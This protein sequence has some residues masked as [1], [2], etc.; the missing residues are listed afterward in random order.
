[1]RIIFKSY[2]KT[3]IN[4]WIQTLGTILFILMMCAIVI[5]MLTSPLQISDKLSRSEQNNNKFDTYIN[6][7]SPTNTKNKLYNAGFIYDYVYQNQDYKVTDPDLKTTKQILAIPANQK[8]QIT[9][10]SDAYKKAVALHLATL[11]ATSQV[12]EQEKQAAV[13]NEIVVGMESFQLGALVDT[14]TSLPLT[15][16]EKNPITA[17]INLI[18]NN[19]L[20]M[21]TADLKVTQDQGSKNSKVRAA[22][23][24]FEYFKTLQAPITTTD[25]ANII[26]SLEGLDD[27]NDAFSAVLLKLVDEKL[28]SFDN[29]VAN[30]QAPLLAFQMF[31]PAM[32]EVLADPTYGY[33][34]QTFINYQVFHNIANR[35]INPDGFGLSYNFQ[36]DVENNYYLSQTSTQ[37]IFPTFALELKNVGKSNALNQLQ[38][39]KGRYPNPITLK[40]WMNQQITPEIVLSSS[41]MKMNKLKVGD[42]I[43]LPSGSEAN[44]VLDATSVD[45]TLSGELKF[46]IVGSGEKYDDLTPGRKYIPFLEDIKNYAIGYVDDTV[47]N[48]IRSTRWNYANTN[49]GNFTSVHR[50]KRLSTNTSVEQALSKNATTN[51]G[52]YD[53]KESSL[54]DATASA[55]QRSLNNLKI[56]VMIYLILGVVVLVLAFIFINFSIRKELN[57]TR[58]Q[59]GIFKSFGYKIAE[60][61]WIFATKTW[62]SISLGVLCG[63]L[64]SIPLQLYSA[65]NYTS[66]L[67]FSFH[68]VYLD[69]LFMALI[70]IV[71]PVLFL[72]VSYLLTLVYLNEPTLS[73]LSNGFKI[74]KIKIH[75]SPLVRYLTKT[76]KGFGYRLQR[77]FV[78]TNF[79]KFVVVQVLFAFASLTFALIFGAQAIMYSTVNQGFSSV[80]KKVDHN[81]YWTNAQELNIAYQTNKYNFKDLDGYQAR[82][83]QYFAYDPDDNQTMSDVLNDNEKTSDSRFRA[84]YLVDS[85][86]NQFDQS[87]DR[88][89]ALKMVMPVDAYYDKYSDQ[90]VNDDTRLQALFSP[91]IIYADYYLN[92]I[93][94]FQINAL[95]ATQV[96]A[97]KN[98]QHF[99]VN[100]LNVFVSA[101]PDSRLDL[102]GALSGDED[103]RAALIANFPNTLFGMLDNNDGLKNNLF[104]SNITKIITLELFE[105]YVDKRVNN[106]LTTKASANDEGK[107]LRSDVDRAIAWAQD[108]A[109]VR[110]FSPNLIKYWGINNNPL[111]NLNTLVNSDPTSDDGSN[112]LSLNKLNKET[113]S[114]VMSSMMLK[115]NP[116]DINQSPTLTINELFYNQKTD[117]LEY[118]LPLLNLDKKKGAGS[119]YLR[120]V[121][122]QSTQYGDYHQVYSLNGVSQEQFSQIAQPT[123]DDSINAILPY[124]L[125]R[126]NNL[127][128]GDVF[129]AQTDTNQR[130]TIKIRVVGINKA[131]TF[132]FT[133]GGWPLDVDYNQFRK[134]FFTSDVN[135]IIDQGLPIFSNLTSQSPLLTG[136]ISLRELSNSVN[137]LK[138]VG[139]N[140]ALSIAPGASVFG[141]IFNGMF[142]F[143]FIDGMK[144]DSNLKMITNPNIASISSQSGI[145]PYNIVRVGVNDAANR[146]NNI[147][148]LFMILEA[149]L[150]LIIL[151]VV[152]NIVVEEQAQVIL[153]LR[154]LGYK[155]REVNWI[156]MGSYIIG[157]LI[158]FVVAY[159]LSLL[160]WWGVLEIAASHWSIYI[161]MTFSWKAPVITFLVIGFILFV[162]WAISDWKVNRTPLTQITSFG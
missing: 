75:P 99:N 97:I 49:T 80:Q 159:L 146:V 56:Q 46:K 129:A 8:G 28:H 106:Y 66:N 45:A 123:L 104:I 142:D 57:E 118:Q 92:W 108:D 94:G 158:S 143:S 27:S 70:F 18:K 77:S 76:G 105:N 13:A 117:F 101:N 110:D 33:N 71:V 53:W 11:T 55:T 34:F 30:K 87:Q 40:Q 41:Y 113:V 161:F 72:G 145:T 107:Y 138:F 128:I 150:L 91:K 14:T 121:D 102:A 74:S 85:I 31:S 39:E 51:N 111:I 160:I 78:R 62:I 96:E 68:H 130:Q 103:A 43:N 19:L 63:Y 29:N 24:M 9:I 67:T 20:E 126:E 82:D 133:N 1:M 135:T 25:L 148:S 154:S 38:I 61:S 12:S 15:D 98:N 64:A 36:Y 2:L 17:N 81:F 131:I 132:R 114:L 134:K 109:V 124:G 44:Q 60:L 136:K 88:S 6:Q 155:K 10:L 116:K 125:A 50:V 7:N 22:S 84:S 23:K 42:V 48:I 73:L 35:D 140:L 26:S 144:I 139:N 100:D 32:Y 16:S 54:G 95:T 59:I 47:F 122:S 112:G 149:V 86:A 151:V 21:L 65:K 89:L 90:P 137:S 93:L 141:S 147:L 37:S 3:F 52:I 157:A 5:G 120:L 152:M 4:N 156:V 153:T 58:K 69:P 115:D 79:G 127:K 119:S 162:G 83:F